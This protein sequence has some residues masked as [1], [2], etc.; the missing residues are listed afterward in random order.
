M[1][2]GAN[3]GIGR[4]IAERLYADGFCL[5]LGA[6]EPSTLEPVVAG[7]DKTRVMTSLWEA[8]TP[9]SS[10][11]WVEHTVQRFGRLDAVV[12]NAGIFRSFDLEDPDESDLDDM[13]EVN[14]KGPL[15][16]VRAAY[17]HLKRGGSGRVV[18]VVSLSGKRV[19][20]ASITGYAMSKHAVL[21]LTHGIRYA[22]WDHGIRATAICPGF[23]DTDMTADVTVVKQSEMIPP[24]AV[25]DMVAAVL[26]LPNGASVTEV[27]I[28]CVLEST[29]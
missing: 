22:G 15:R 8:K 19:K 29:Y 17:P 12:N 13:W 16:L 23:V 26:A 9:S 5:S 11:T 28:N 18:N 27:P 21:A 4:A 24:A 14:T 7:M 20:S 10:T 2:S 25:A 3:R 1:I 6:R